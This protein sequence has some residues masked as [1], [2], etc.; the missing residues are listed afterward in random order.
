MAASFQWRI[1]EILAEKLLL[2]AADTGAKRV[3]IAGGV[4]ANRALRERLEAG[5]R[6]LGA[7]LY[8]PCLLYTSQGLGADHLADGVHRAVGRAQRPHGGVRHAGHGRQ[9]RAL[10]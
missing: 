2:A 4:A 8:L 6:R 3:C 1:T 10:F 7:K 9:G 5:A